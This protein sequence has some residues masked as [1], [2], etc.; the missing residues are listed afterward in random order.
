[1]KYVRYADDFLIGIIGSKED[2]FKL[3][4]IICSFLKEKLKLDLNLD[5]TKITH[6]RNSTAHFLGTDIRITPL[7][8]RPV[9]KII[10]GGTTLITS[11]S[12]R[13]QLLIPISKLVRKLEEKG[14]CRQGGNP[15][16]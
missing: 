4:N 5:K 11:I 6:A 7:D 16:R 2:S 10:R 14:F 8:K 15:T 13:P 12:T 1:L 9:R 3:R